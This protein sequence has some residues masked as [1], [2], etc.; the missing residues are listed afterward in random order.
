MISLDR[1]EAKVNI[2]RQWALD[3]GLHNIECFKADA[4]LLVPYDVAETTESTTDVHD[5]SAPKAADSEGPSEKTRARKRSGKPRD[6]CGEG[7]GGGTGIGGKEPLRFQRESFDR[8]V[9]DPPCTALG[10]RPRLLVDVP[11]IEMQRTAGYQVG[12]VRCRVQGFEG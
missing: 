10:L 5:D 9:L 8:I 7:E 2:I 1:T 12:G 6:A 3:L 4:T 11:E